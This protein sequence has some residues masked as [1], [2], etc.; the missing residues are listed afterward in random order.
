[1]CGLI[2]SSVILFDAPYVP[3][4]AL[5]FRDGEA[6][7]FVVRN[8][9]ISLAKV[10]SETMTDARWKSQGRFSRRSDHG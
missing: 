1:M 10:I 7:V 6:Y 8:D 2:W 3:D 4:D 5:T 9:H